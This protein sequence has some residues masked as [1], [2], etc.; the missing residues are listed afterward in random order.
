V[1]AHRT[2]A[3]SLGWRPKRWPDV[4]ETSATIVLW[5]KRSAAS[6]E[7]RDAVERNL[8]KLPKHFADNVKDTELP[9]PIADRVVHVNLSDLSDAAFLHGPGRRAVIPIHRL[10]KIVEALRQAGL[11][12][13]SDDPNP[14]A[15]R[16]GA[17]WPDVFKEARVYGA[18]S[19]STVFISHAGNDT[20]RIL[21]SVMARTILNVDLRH[22]N[23]Q[24]RPFP[25]Y[26]FFY[27]TS[28]PTDYVER[29]LMALLD[30]RAALIVLSQNSKANPW[31]IAEVDWLLEHCKKIGVCLLDDTDPRE[32]HPGLLVR[33]S[34][35]GIAIHRTIFDLRTRCD[36][37]LE[38]L[39]VW[40]P[41]LPGKRS[42][43][44]P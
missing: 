36:D 30:C 29:V 42:L 27:S 38:E 22:A 4:Y 8:P 20:P 40:L 35:W 25:K 44:T 5:S 9:K 3:R 16:L 14:H 10:D 31:V 13:I 33:R 34:V 37:V 23:V 18:R 19:G 17:L 1:A 24:P 2:V 41:P 28:R 6:E 26:C 43:P 21:S 11:T 32:L 12:W 7:F 39:N 15:S